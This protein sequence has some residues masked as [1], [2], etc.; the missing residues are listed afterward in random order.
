[1]VNDKKLDVSHAIAGKL[2]DVAIKKTGSIKVGGLITAIAKYLDFNIENMPFE[3]VAGRYFIDTSMMEAIGLVRIDHTRRAFLIQPTPPK[4]QVE[5][6]EEDISINDVVERL[7]NLELQVGV[8]DSN[9]GELNSEVRRMGR[10]SRKM[11]CTLNMI[12]HNLSAYFSSQNFIPLPFPIDEEM[13]EQDS[14]FEEE[15]EE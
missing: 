5:E 1:M 4:A 8:I 2:R 6:E 9:V 13:E 3:K 7:D 12:N 11:N 15:G 10:T 14:S